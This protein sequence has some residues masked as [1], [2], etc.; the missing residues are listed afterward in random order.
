MLSGA[1]KD[2]SK[3]VFYEYHTLDALADYL[4]R[5]YYKDCM[6]WTGL[7]DRTQVVKE[8][9]SVKGDNNRRL[10]VPK[11][12]RYTRKKAESIINTSEYRKEREPIAIIGL[13][14]RF[15]K[16]RNMEEYWE[17][18]KSGKDCITEIP[19]ERWPL[20]GFYHP[21]PGEAAAQ[22]KSYSKWGGF[23]DGFSEFDPLFFNISP[24]E[25]VNIDPQERL[26]IESCWEVLEDAGYTREQLEA[27]YKGRV[28][29]FAGI[30]KTGFD[31]Y[32]PDLWRQGEQLF[33]YT[34][35]SSVANRVSYLFNLHGPSIPVDTMC[36][37]SLTAVHEACEHIHNGDCDIAIAGGVN[38]YLHPSSY[39]G[40]CGQNMLSRDG[41]CKSFRQRR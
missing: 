29:V 33:P 32:G 36:S 5:D 13:S 16:S 7:M 17:N 26:F 23:I 22:G 21:D 4:I 15:P 14:G 39:I 3:T 18:L 11:S 20:D 6:L 28:G 25:A 24:R 35:F 31:L 41:R 40:L 2:I 30:T 37:S 27:Q 9:I 34:S 10:P 38:L 8:E 19:Q 12:F 1:F